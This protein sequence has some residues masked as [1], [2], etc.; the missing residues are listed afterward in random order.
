MHLLLLEHLEPVA[1]VVSGG[2]REEGKGAGGDGGEEERVK[3]EG[4]E[5]L[6]LL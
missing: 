5:L 1:G 4:K 6:L 2:G 3:V